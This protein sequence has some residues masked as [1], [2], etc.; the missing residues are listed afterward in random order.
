QDDV[1]GTWSAA[2]RRLFQKAGGDFEV[3]ESVEAIPAAVRLCAERYRQQGRAF[4]AP[5]EAVH[6]IAEALHEA[7]LLR[8]FIASRTS[9]G[10]AEAGLLALVDDRCAYYWIAGSRPGPAMTVL[11]AEALPRLFADGQR[12]IDYVGANTPSIAEF[13]RR[14]GGVLTP[15]YRIE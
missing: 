4:P 2:A 7:R 9:T 6:R 1:L 8:P 3:R 10:E 14:L 12:E 13:K 15:Y 5:A 11:L